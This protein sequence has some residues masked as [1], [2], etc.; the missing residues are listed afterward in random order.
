MRNYFGLIAIS[1]DLLRHYVVVAPLSNLLNFSRQ[2]C[3]EWNLIGY[4]AIMIGGSMVVTMFAERTYLFA[5]ITVHTG[6]IS[7]ARARD[8]FLQ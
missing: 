6:D 2:I 4:Y 8:P 5:S 7:S 1:I 3:V